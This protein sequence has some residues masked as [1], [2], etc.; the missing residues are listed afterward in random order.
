ML[1]KAKGSSLAAELL[2]SCPKGLDVTL[3]AEGAALAGLMLLL[4]VGRSDVLVDNS[5]V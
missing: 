4:L 1:R 2:G 3:G 5:G